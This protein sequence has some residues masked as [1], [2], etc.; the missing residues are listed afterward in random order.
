MAEH[1]PSTERLGT[2]GQQVTVVQRRLGAEALAQCAELKEALG[3]EEPEDV[4]SQEVG[5]VWNPSSAARAHNPRAS[6]PTAL[7]SLTRVLTAGPSFS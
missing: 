1:L 6:Y 3:V 4:I 5:E 2:A 7:H